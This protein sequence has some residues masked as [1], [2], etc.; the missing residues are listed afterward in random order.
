[1]AWISEPMSEEPLLP[2]SSVPSDGKL[3]LARIYQPSPSAMQSALAERRRGWVL[4]FEPWQR[5]EIEPLMGW[6]ATRDPFTSFY[7][8]R[9]PDRQSAITSPNATAGSTSLNLRRCGVSASRATPTISGD[10]GLAWVEWVL[11]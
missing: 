10:I 5:K 3:P 2:G 11:M 6:T 1:M 7:G 8:L 4:E 9:F